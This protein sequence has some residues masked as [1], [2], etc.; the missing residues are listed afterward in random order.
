M[1]K[2]AT[3]HD[4]MVDNLRDLYSAEKQLVQAL[5]RLAKG[6]SDPRLQ[7]AFADHLEATK[8]H[9]SR[10]EEA[11]TD[12]DLSARA[13]HCKGMEGL[14]EEGKEIL[15][16]D[17]EPAVLDAG[18]I[19]A[20][21]RVEHYEIAAYGSAIAMAEQMGHTTVAE[22]LR[23]TLDEEKQADQ[24][25]SG[26]A[27]GGINADANAGEEGRMPATKSTAKAAKG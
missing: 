22:L 8:Q 21:Q 1:T 18:L 15:G 9:V 27:E 13:K 4:L 10:L 20:A 3:L 24:L 16:A 14:L 17:G 23:R 19:S 11:F 26:I 12:L 6:A 7:S 2:L 25:L 5:P